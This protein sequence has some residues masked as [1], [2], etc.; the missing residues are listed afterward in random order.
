M[1][2]DVTRSVKVG[3]NVLQV[4]GEFAGKNSVVI[5]YFVIL[6]KQVL[7]ITLVMYK[8]THFFFNR[9]MC[10]LPSI[11]LEFEFHSVCL[12]GALPSMSL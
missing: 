3:A 5:T 9:K 12:M 7:G 6:Q 1:P 2:T 10:G 4:I 11:G 8:I